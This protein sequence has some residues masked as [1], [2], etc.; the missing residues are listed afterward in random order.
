MKRK[1]F[2]HV[3]ISFRNQHSLTQVECAALIP[4]LSVR[5]IEKWERSGSEPPL[6]TQVLL[7]DALRDAMISDKNI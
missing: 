2:A 3:L 1:I 4:E 7:L 5:M 6:W